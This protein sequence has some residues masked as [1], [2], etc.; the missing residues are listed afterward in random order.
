MMASSAN[1]RAIDA[2]RARIGRNG[3]INKI[4]GFE[5]DSFVVS[6]EKERK[7]KGER[8]VHTR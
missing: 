6:P 1:S 5:N 7:D 3:V 2:V 4:V 8:V